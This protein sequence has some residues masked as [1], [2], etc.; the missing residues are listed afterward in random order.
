MKIINKSWLRLVVL[1]YVL[2]TP[3]TLL[4]AEEGSGPCDKTKQICNP[5]QAGSIEEMIQTILT[6]MKEIGFP[7]LALAIVYC[8]FLF[9]FARG[10]PEKISKAKTALIY[11]MIGGAILL[12]AYALAQMISS[13]VSGL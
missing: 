7:I 5:I 1:F 6:G 3:L 12:G 11:T 4:Y 10:N 13:T 9:V 8:G 2:F